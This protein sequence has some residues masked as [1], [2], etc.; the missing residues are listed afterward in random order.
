M[1]PNRR[2]LQFASIDEIMPEVDR[3]LQ[4]NKTVGQWTFG[5]ICEHLATVNRA[6][7]DNPADSKPDQSLRDSDEMK[8]NSSAT[9][10]FRKADQCQAS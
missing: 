2:A 6:L 8:R 7:V 5:Q 1:N 10:T 3:L 4:G 9:A